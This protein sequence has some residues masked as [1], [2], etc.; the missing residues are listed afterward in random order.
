[1]VGFLDE[2]IELDGFADGDLVA[3][4]VAH[5]VDEASD[6]ADAVSEGGVEG[7]TELGVVVFT[8][9]E[10]LVSGEGDHGVT[11]LVGEAVGHLADEPEVRGFEFEA[12]QLFGLGMV[13]DDEEGGRGELSVLALDGE[14]GDVVDGFRCILGAVFEGGDTGAGF[15][16][17]IDFT[18]EGLWEV[19]EFEFG[20]PAAFTGEIMACGFIGVEDAEISADDD[21]AA[22][23]LAEYVRHHVVVGGELVMEPDILDGEAE[24]FEEV[25][26][27]FEFG[28]GEGVAG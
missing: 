25:E 24:G 23:E 7:G 21:T 16:H 9:E 1:M 18:A 26:D 17:L 14:D 2:G 15:Q 3:C 20:V 19:A 13:L 5:L 27:E 8:G 11:D 22:A 12:V 6:A 10:L 4:E 28:V